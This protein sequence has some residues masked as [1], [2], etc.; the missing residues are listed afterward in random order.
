MT[1]LYPYMDSDLYSGQCV[2]IGDVSKH[3]SLLSVPID[4]ETEDSDVASS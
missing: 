1:Y 3:R 2:P 4:L